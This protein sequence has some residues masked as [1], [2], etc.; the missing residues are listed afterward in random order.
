MQNLPEYYSEYTELKNSDYTEKKQIV[1][2][3]N[4]RKHFESW[5]NLKTNKGGNKNF[6]YVY[7]KIKEDTFY[8]SRNNNG[9]LD[10]LVGCMKLREFNSKFSISN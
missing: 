6:T 2:V 10:G 1:I 3:L 4:N 9:Y 8:P 5:Y 7:Y